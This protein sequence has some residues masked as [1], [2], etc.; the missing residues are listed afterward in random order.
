MPNADAVRFV[1]CGSPATLAI[2][3]GGLGLFG[4]LI[5]AMLW[6]IVSGSEPVLRW[7]RALIIGAVVAAVGLAGVITMRA[8]GLC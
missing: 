2:I 8:R 1:A 3:Q 4:G 7:R 6:G 5:I